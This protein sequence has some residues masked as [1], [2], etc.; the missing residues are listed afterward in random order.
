MPLTAA[1]CWAAAFPFTADAFPFWTGGW[2]D[3]P[4]AD[5]AWLESPAA[6]VPDLLLLPPPRPWNGVGVADCW[7]IPRLL[8]K[9]SACCNK[10][11]GIN[12]PYIEES[13]PT[14]LTA[15]CSCVSLSAMAKNLWR[16]TTTEE[17]RGVGHEEEAAPQIPRPS[18]TT[19]TSSPLSSTSLTPS[20]R[21][22]TGLSG[23]SRRAWL[24]NQNA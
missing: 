5:A 3:P 11:Q 2:L 16:A 9:L 1:G 23:G 22:P 19:R 7:R 6:E 4:P 10:I 12:W 17:K 20:R 15:S 13:P 24:Q 14:A 18:R 21:P 8:V